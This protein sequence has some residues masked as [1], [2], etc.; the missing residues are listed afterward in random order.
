MFYHSREKTIGHRSL[1]PVV[2]LYQGSN[3]AKQ[4]PQADKTYGNYHTLTRA[5]VGFPVY[6]LELEGRT[7]DCCQTSAAM[8]GLV[9]INHVSSPR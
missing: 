3:P 5:I 6:P 9:R 2:F 7:C 8:S 1:F 4:L